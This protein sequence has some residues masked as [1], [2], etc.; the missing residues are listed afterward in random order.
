VALRRGLTNAPLEVVRLDN[1]YHVATMDNDAAEIFRGSAEF[2]RSVAL[3][4]SS[5]AA[6]ASRKD[7][8]N[9]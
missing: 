5:D 6:P 9:D 3:P 8:A 1:S 4:A 2:V 7:T